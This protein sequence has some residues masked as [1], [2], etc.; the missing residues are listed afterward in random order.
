MA[1]TVRHDQKRSITATELW[2][3]CFGTAN[4]AVNRR[5]NKPTKVLGW[6]TNA[7]TRPLMLD[8]L[9]I[10]LREESFSLWDAE[11]VAEC[12]TFARDDTGKPVANEGCH[13]DRVISA[14]GAL[15]IARFVHVPRPPVMQKP[16]LVGSSPTGDFTQK[17]ALGPSSAAG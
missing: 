8:G 14:A 13:D 12:F 11:T 9:A 1:A 15:A 5:E 6:V 2:S 7:E 4:F 17:T 3:P 10:G 16:E